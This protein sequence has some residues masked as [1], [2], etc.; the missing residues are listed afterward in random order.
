MLLITAPSKTQRPVNR[1]FPVHTLPV[2]FDDS[3]RLTEKLRTYSPNELATLMKI[4]AT[5]TESTLEKIQSFLPRLTPENSAQAIFTF[6][7]DAYSSLTPEEY[8]EEELLHAQ[9]HIRIL[10]GLYGILRPLDLIFPYRLEMGCK[11]ENEKGKNLYTYW[12]DS[13]TE[14]I[15]RDIAR[16]SDKT[17]INLA[18]AEYTKVIRKKILSPRMVSITFKEKKGEIIKTIPIHSKRARGMMLH[19]VIINRLNT[20]ASLKDFDLGGYGFEESLSS[21]DNWIFVRG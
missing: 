17:L 10:S 8:T 18:S 20:S 19:Y 21:E 4:S 3:T 15:N 9:E 2:F 1:K 11:L 7:G 13:L 16:H 5:L 14:A 12:G 6:Q